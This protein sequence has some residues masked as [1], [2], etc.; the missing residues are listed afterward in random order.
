MLR[1]LI[2]VNL[3]VFSYNFY[4][5]GEYDRP[6]D[7]LN[8]FISGAIFVVQI[9]IEILRSKFIN[10]EKFESSETLQAKI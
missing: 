3:A 10:L 6:M 7:S 9:S 2:C 8:T 4:V 5:M 1:C